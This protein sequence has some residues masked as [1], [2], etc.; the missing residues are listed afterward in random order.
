MP[1][2]YNHFTRRWFE[3]KSFDRTILA[4]DAT[5]QN[6][7][8][9]APKSAN[10]TLFIQKITFT[11]TTYAAQDMV[12]QDNA[13][14]PVPIARFSIAAAAPTTGGLSPAYIADFGPKGVALTAG[15]QL[16]IINTA[17]PAGKLHIECYEKNTNV[18]INFNTSLNSDGNVVSG[19]TKTAVQ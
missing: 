19:T 5:A 1:G 14:T 15:K 12:F 7:G 6:A 4:T 2:D 16:D 10:Y 8:V 13:G 11:P 3:D 9:V 18:A 17:G